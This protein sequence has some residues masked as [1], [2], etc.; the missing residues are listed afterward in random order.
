M[1]FLTWEDGTA[2]THI[3]EM[4]A[5][6]Q[7]DWGPIN[8][9]YA[10]GPQPDGDRF[11]EAYGHRL[12]CVP[13]VTAPLTGERLSQR[14]RAMKPSALGLDGWALQDLRAL[15]PDLMDWPAELLCVVERMGRLPGAPTCGYTAL[16]PKEGPPG[17]LNTCPL[18]VPSIVYCLWAGAR[19]QEAMAW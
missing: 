19:P 14:A 4:D 7:R 16:V 1:V 2:T 18:T 13:M 3:P 11:M 12:R 6:L 17:A 10:D 8:R 9:K 5:L 15:P